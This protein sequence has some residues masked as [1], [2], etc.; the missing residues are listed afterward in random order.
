MRNIVKSLELEVDKNIILNL[1]GANER[2][3]QS[4]DNMS[5]FRHDFKNILQE[6]VDVL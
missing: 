6:W 5:S 3:R 4:F 2:L 1:T